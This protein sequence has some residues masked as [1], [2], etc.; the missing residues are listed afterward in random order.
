MPCPHS[1][2]SASSGASDSRREFLKAA[3]AIG[4]A[5]A[6]SACMKKEKG[7]A[8]AASEQYPRGPSDLSSLPERQHAWGEYLRRN[9]FGTTSLPTHHAMLLLNYAGDGT[10]TDEERERAEAAFRTL[11]R[12]FQ[13]GTGG[14]S[15]AVKHEGLLFVVGYSSTYFERFDESLPSSL[16]LQAPEAVLEATGETEP[17]ADSFDAV[18]HLASG[19]ASVILGAEEALFGELGR[20]NGVDVEGGLAGTFERAERRTGF[21]GKGLPAKRYE[22]EH[23]PEEAPLAMGYQSG[24]ADSLPS[25]DR[26]SIREGPFADG[27]TMQVSRLNID[28]ESWYGESHEERRKLMFSP[29]HS[30]AEV[31]DF[32]ENLAGDSGI[33]K[34]IADRV[35]SDARE[36]E[37]LGHSQKLARARDEEFRARILR[38]DFDGTAEPSLHF[39]S[40]QRDIGDFVDTRK[41]MQGDDFDEA[42]PDGHNG[43]LDHI[44]VTNRATFLMPPRRLRSLP[45]PRP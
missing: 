5:S 40:W 3:V 36:E 11:E 33:T 41:A 22:G 43:I 28:D 9:R 37:I 10:P 26:I 8:E 12:A 7:R 35:P 2:R 4:G 27:T 17:T 30:H 39:D 13:R 44:E 18:V 23:F 45:T 25:E 15:R 42:L 31:G 16:D 32:G 21:I 20:L 14:D 6:L 19:H 38:R 24:F 29:E 1:G 34:E